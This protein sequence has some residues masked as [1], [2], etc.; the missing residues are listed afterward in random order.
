VANSLAA[1]RAGIDWVVQ[2][3]TEMIAVIYGLVISREP[4]AIQF[5]ARIAADCWSIFNAPQQAQRVWC[6]RTT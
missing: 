5:S 6:F 2:R 1:Y 4:G 3:P